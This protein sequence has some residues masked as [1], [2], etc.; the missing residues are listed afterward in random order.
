[1]LWASSELVF[2][3]QRARGRRTSSGS[4]GRKCGLSFKTW[5]SGMKTPTSMVTYFCRQK[6]KLKRK[7]MCLRGHLAKGQ[8]EELSAAQVASLPKGTVISRLRFIPKTDNMRP[9]TRVTGADP[10]TRVRCEAV[11][12]AF[13][14]ISRFIHRLSPAG[15]P[16]PCQRAAG[17]AAGLC[18]L[19]SVP[20]RLHGVGPD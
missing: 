19:H 16:G 2:M 10:K 5:P 13:L 9:I 11:M 17:H 1:M 20:P 8:L 14:H 15:L 3:Q 6:V 18:A 12:V 4:T 7:L